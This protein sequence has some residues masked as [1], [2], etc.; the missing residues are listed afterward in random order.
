MSD[1]TQNEKIRTP[2]ILDQ[3][4]KN[5]KGT[6]ALP[7]EL[8]TNT[9]EVYTNPKNPFLGRI[10]SNEVPPLDRDPQKT[11][12]LFQEIGNKEGY[13]KNFLGSGNPHLKRKVTSSP[14]HSS[15]CKGY[16]GEPSLRED[17]NRLQT[18]IEAFFS[19]TLARLKEDQN[20]LPQLVNNLLPLFVEH[21]IRIRIFPA[22]CQFQSFE[23]FIDTLEL[24][25]EDFEIENFELFCS[26]LFGYY[27]QQG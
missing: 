1:E 2:L 13:C 21:Q 15:I 23:Q 19:H 11:K 20:M 8:G 5:T 7:Y 25:S 27:S 4:P 9:Y 17:L 24:I 3:S 14:K 18:S 10:L 22:Y 26:A 12:N 16:E 6:Q